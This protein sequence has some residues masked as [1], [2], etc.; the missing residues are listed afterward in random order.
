MWLAVILIKIERRERKR[1][2]N[3]IFYFIIFGRTIFSFLGSE[4]ED[5]SWV[6]VSVLNSQFFGVE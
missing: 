3:N 2:K 6:L 1:R 5:L 4:R